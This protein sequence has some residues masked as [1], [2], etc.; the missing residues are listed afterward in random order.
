MVTTRT[1]VVCCLA[2]ALVSAS[3]ASAQVSRVGSTLTLWGGP[4]PTD[5]ATR[6]SGIAYDPKSDVYL[7]VSAH[8]TVRGR[9][10]AGDG[11]PIATAFVVAPSANFQ[12]F[13]QVAY[14]PDADGGAGGFLVSWH[15]SDQSP[16]SVHV[17]LIS[18]QHGFI[19]A[20][21]RIP[22]SASF[23][24][25]APAVAYATGSREFL[26]VWR[27]F[28]PADIQAARVSVTGSVVGGVI[29]VSNTADFEDHPSVT[30]NPGTDEFFVVYTGFSSASTLYGRR[31]RAG[32]LVGGPATIATGAGIYITDAAYDSITG[33][34]L[35][36]WYEGSQPASY[37]R[38]LNPDGSPAGAVTALSTR[39][40]SYDALGLA[41]NRTT[42]TFFLVSH[43][44]ATVE[45]GGVEVGP[46]GVPLSGGLIVTAA[47]GAGNFYPKITAHASQPDWMVV[48]AWSFQ[49]T[50]A[51]RLTSGTRSGGTP[52]PTPAPG[53]APAPAPASTNP[54]M[55]IDTPA[56][57]TS[58][59]GA[60]TVAGW[61]I[62]YGAPSGTG[63]DAV[64]VWAY[65]TSGAAPT[66]VG[67]ASLGVARPDV[68]A[69]FGSSRFTPSGFT[70][71][72]A[73]APGAYDVV[74]Y[75]HSMVTGTFN[76][77]KIVR[78][79]ITAPLS[80]PRMAVDAP[81]LNQNL[82]RNFIVA[83]WAIDLGAAVGAGVDTVH[84][85]AYP[86]SGAAP[87]FV[88]SATVDGNRS[89][90]AAAFGAG[91]RFGASGFSLTVSGQLPPDTYNLVIF[92]HSTVTGTFNNAIVIRVRVL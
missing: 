1:S 85:W 5:I 62:D 92:A 19:G 80:N 44:S 43:D 56:T 60:V 26:V 6:G 77:A 39:Y 64:H 91:S 83:G 46:N 59:A 58:A 3:P 22:T 78:V 25:S 55:S 29:T 36:G 69:A 18:Y 24:E 14:S 89:D 42:G 57:N 88:G 13:P 61:A 63:I 45:D 72:G 66:L 82:S 81:A 41:H 87:I 27:S 21:T 52:A 68:G 30:Y 12:Q 70:V 67:V 11:S 90:V 16:T 8:G 51:Q 76:N 65:P 37:G 71:T 2:L 28:A 34:Y 54:L 84:V 40:K 31:L 32:Q 50:M 53:P 86:V 17:R 49:A 10:I 35:V 9:F 48:T 74:A 47:G 79:T 20:D 15:E 73:L 75:A 33:L 4:P 23:W 7:A 38:L